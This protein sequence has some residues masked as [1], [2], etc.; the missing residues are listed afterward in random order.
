MM[1]ISPSLW[2]IIS[3]AF[4]AISLVP[5]FIA[6]LKGTNKP[7]VFTWVIWTLLTAM[8]FAVQFR[9]GA[10]AGAW[11]TGFS[12][13]CCVF[14]LLASLRFGEKNITRSDWV[15]FIAALAAIPIWVVT[16]NPALA[17][18]WVT[19]IDGLGFYP[20]CRKSWH[21]PFE[22]M[23]QSHA[24]SCV[25]HVFSLLA[26]SAVSIATAFYPAALVVF[27]LILIAIILVRR[28]VLS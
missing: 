10:G 13:V 3:V 9:E 4:A 2:G 15:T 5:Y 20:P 8:A 1:S 11:A 24:L 26:L 17:A 16:K 18:I 6:T 12:A 19:L 25:K 21:K 22:E 23:W 7:H 27:N 28:R 14:I